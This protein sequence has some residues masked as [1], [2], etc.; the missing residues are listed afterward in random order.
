[1]APE[2][3]AAGKAVPVQ[4]ARPL[5]LIRDDSVV[6]RASWAQIL[7][8]RRDVELSQSARREGHSCGC[9]RRRQDPPGRLATPRGRLNSTL[10]D[11]EQSSGDRSSTEALPGFGLVAGRAPSPH[12]AQRDGCGHRS[13]NSRFC[14]PATPAWPRKL[15]LKPHQC[16]C[17]RHGI[18]LLPGAPPADAS[19]GPRHP[20]GPGT[21]R[22]PCGSER[23]F[24]SAMP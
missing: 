5:H 15:G 7:E 3:G 10:G 23:P 17:L 9:R 19:T 22:T 12:V 16:A 13:R 4:V 8:R 11:A 6:V 2:A 18:V 24:H 20:G 14:G 21:G 1:M